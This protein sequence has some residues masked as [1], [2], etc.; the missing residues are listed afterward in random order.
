LDDVEWGREEVERL[1]NAAPGCVFVLGSPERHLW[2][3]GCPIALRGLPIDAALTLMEQRLGRAITPR[4]RPLAQALCK[5][6]GR[7]PLRLV[8]AIGLVQ[9]GSKTLAELASELVSEAPE[10]L[11][12]KRAVASCTESEQRA[13]AVLAALGGLSAST[14]HLGALAELENPHDV[15]GSL[16]ERGL[17]L[18]EGTRC[19]LAGM[20]VKPLAKK[21]DLTPSSKRALQFY[22]AW[23]DRHDARQ[24]H[25]RILEEV[26]VLLHSL[27]WAVQAQ[28]WR[29]VLQ[30]GRAMEDALA[31]R[32]RWGAWRQV[33]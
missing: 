9:D 1:L 18:A 7:H 19:R 31:L 21:W 12:A 25:A 5:A 13:L 15:L 10:R 29:Q 27:T 17:I 11:L 14:K 20:L 26:D 3:E 24:D 8:Q 22:A 28:R 6:T 30:L 32:G 2:D 16:R 23:A 4:E 33:L